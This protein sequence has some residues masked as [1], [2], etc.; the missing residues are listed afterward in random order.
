MCFWQDLR[1]SRRLVVVGIY[2]LPRCKAP[3]IHDALDKLSNV[4]RKAKD[5]FDDP[6]I[7]VGGDFN[8]TNEQEA[9]GDFPD[10]TVV[11]SSPTRLTSVLDKLLTNYEEQIFNSYICPPLTTNDNKA[12]IPS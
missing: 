10:M 5:T 11:S 2:I 8:R 4:I 12:T 3:Q 6:I 1:K 7:V 9:I